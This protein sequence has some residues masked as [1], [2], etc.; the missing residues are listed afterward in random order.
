MFWERASLQNALSSQK[1]SFRRRRR[2]GREC[3]RRPCSGYQLPLLSRCDCDGHRR[4]RGRFRRCR[5]CSCRCGWSTPRLVRR[6]SFRQQRKQRAAT[7]PRLF[8]FDSRHVPVTR[9]GKDRLLRP[10]V[11]RDDAVGPRSLFFARR[12][13]ALLDSSPLVA[14]P[15]SSLVV[16]H[17]RLG[18]HENSGPR[19]QS[20]LYD[21]YCRDAHLLFYDAV[22]QGTIQAHRNSQGFALDQ[23]AVARPTTTESECH[24][25]TG[26]ARR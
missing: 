18:R 17:S 20:G 26:A 1:A 5:I 23:G 3:T 11:L 9:D 19:S 15:H 24:S 8:D 16:G 21:K 7:T 12:D 2:R 13:A 22:L 4:R 25:R 14:S 6:P 10:H